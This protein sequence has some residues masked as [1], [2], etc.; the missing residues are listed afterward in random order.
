MVAIFIRRISK[1]TE[2]NR[3]DNRLNDDQDEAS[4][5]RQG[6]APA[7]RPQISEPSTAEYS[8]DPI[9]S[10]GSAVSIAN[11]SMGDTSH[12][13]SPS[14]DQ[15]DGQRSAF[16]SVQP[17]VPEGEEEGAARMPRHVTRPFEEP[18]FYYQ[19]QHQAEYQDQGYSHY[20]SQ[21]QYSYSRYPP[22]D[23]QNS[24]TLSGGQYH[25][26]YPSYHPQEYGHHHQHHPQ[27]YGHHQPHPQEYGYHQPDYAQYSYYPS[28]ARG[29]YPV[30]PPHHNYPGATTP[31]P[32]SSQPN[33]LIEAP[34][35]VT[36]STKGTPSHMA[37]KSYDR[38]GQGLGIS[39]SP[40]E[41]DRKP[42][43]SKQQ[44]RR[45]TRINEAS[46]P[47]QPQDFEPIPLYEISA[48]P[49]LSSSS[50]A[51]RMQPSSSQG[52]FPKA[53]TQTSTSA[54]TAS[55]AH[56]A[57]PIPNSTP[58][59]RPQSRILAPSSSGSNTSSTGVEGGSWE[60]RF[61]EL[62][63]FKRAHGHCEV[64]QSYADNNS[65]GTWVNKVSYRMNNPFY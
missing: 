44:G 37:R 58:T 38:Y 56:V 9:E 31:T 7:I 21:N 53:F 28:G 57:P 41:D 24:A 18:H 51:A 17:D 59:P 64:P 6:D 13:K 20:Q 10:S 54:A 45:E 1:D 52:A 48:I 14:F 65:L 8:R 15:R 33:N 12:T 26:P 23:P 22:P 50:S 35:V 32:H 60:K 11:A 19:P 55:S 27:E 61:A 63:G 49:A 16:S 3:H 62:C 34:S 29:Q 2:M 46:P 42:S 43:S 36:E 40:T 25:P 30:Q 5:Q 47:Q 39:Q 4:L